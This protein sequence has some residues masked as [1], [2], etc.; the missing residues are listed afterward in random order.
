[1]IFIFD[2]WPADST[3]YHTYRDFSQAAIAQSDGSVHVTYITFDNKNPEQNSFNLIVDRLRTED[4][5]A[6][7]GQE[8]SP[9]TLKNRS[10]SSILKNYTHYTCISIVLLVSNLL[11]V[12][13][14]LAN[15]SFCRPA[16]YSAIELRIYVYEI[17]IFRN[18]G[19]GVV[20]E[21]P[22]CVYARMYNFE[23]L[24]GL[25]SNAKGIIRMWSS[26]NIS[27]RWCSNIERCVKN[28]TVH[29]NKIVESWTLEG[30]DKRRTYRYVLVA[31]H[32]EI[33]RSE[34]PKVKA[35]WNT[36]IS[37]CS[38]FGMSPLILR[39]TKEIDSLRLRSST[40]YCLILRYDLREQNYTLEIL[41]GLKQSEQ[42]EQHVGH[43]YSWGEKRDLLFSRWAPGEP[44]NTTSKKCVRW[45]ITQYG[46]NKWY[47]VGCGE[48]TT[49]VILCGEDV[50]PHNIRMYFNTDSNANISEVFTRGSFGQVISKS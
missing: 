40:I 6:D 23:S 44:R 39:N 25:I 2:E 8:R 36:G 4:F 17:S 32:A 7:F 38:G 27:V 31:H 11:A 14:N 41:S 29:E 13:S 47:S 20:N 9:Q 10:L 1:M 30:E 43:R 46:D 49:N 37:V 26:F 18:G 19:N 22:L 50:P 35:D 3:T 21:Y 33:W 45:S 24:Q 48:E 16:R 15:I 34:P 42:S 12:R 5:T 28:L